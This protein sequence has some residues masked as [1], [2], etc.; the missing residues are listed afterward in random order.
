MSSQALKLKLKSTDEEI[1]DVWLA[2]IIFNI[3]KQKCAINESLGDFIALFS[4]GHFIVAILES[5][6]I[7]SIKSKSFESLA[8]NSANDTR[9]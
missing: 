6:I 3:F 7:S 8:I 1:S 9:L 2:L 5:S 4:S